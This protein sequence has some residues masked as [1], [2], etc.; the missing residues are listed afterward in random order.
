MPSQDAEISSAAVEAALAAVHRGQCIGR[1][2]L[3]FFRVRFAAG[4]VVDL[5]VSFL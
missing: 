4:S 1:P 5:V 3:R 2:L